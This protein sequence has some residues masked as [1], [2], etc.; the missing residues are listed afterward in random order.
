MLRRDNIGAYKP[1]G[2]FYGLWE[3]SP[4]G[5]SGAEHLSEPE[6]ARHVARVGPAAGPTAGEADAALDPEEAGVKDSDVPEADAGGAPPPFRATVTD[7]QTSTAAMQTRSR[8][9]MNTLGGLRLLAPDSVPS[10]VP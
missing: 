6:V 1:L 8:L 4:W 9:H 3:V 10:V 5:A 2:L 7:T